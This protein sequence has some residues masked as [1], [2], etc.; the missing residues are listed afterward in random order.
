MTLNF[1]SRTTQ[2]DALKSSLDVSALRTRAIAD[3][4]ARASIKQPEFAVP[5]NGTTATTADQE[6][7]NLEN[8]MV[9]L[10]DE[11]LRYQATAKFLEKAYA[12]LRASLQSK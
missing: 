11:Q 12:G 5:M 9:G 8:E 1:I 7:F 3:R 2:V 6:S 10:A 4:V